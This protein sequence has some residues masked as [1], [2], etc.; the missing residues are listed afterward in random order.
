M[1][2]RFGKVDGFWVAENV[3]S[4]YGQ[5]NISERRDEISI[6][7][8]TEKVIQYLE[9]SGGGKFIIFN[10]MPKDQIVLQTNSQTT[11]NASLSWISCSLKF[12]DS[13]KR[14]NTGANFEV[15]GKDISIT[16]YA[17]LVK[18]SGAKI[19]SQDFKEYKSSSDISISAQS[20]VNENKKSEL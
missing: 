16:R 3:L 17:I 7:N 15:G 2:S 8:Q 12:A 9:I 10:L 20:P 6:V 4:F 19:E 13:E 5:P 11:K 14:F 1:D 18:D